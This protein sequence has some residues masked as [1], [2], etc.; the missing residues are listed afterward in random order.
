MK[1]Q[2]FLLHFAGGN[3]YSLQRI[4][5]YLKD[6]DVILPELPGRGK[7]MNECLLRDFDLAV[8]DLYEQITRKL[9]AADFLIYGHSM[10]AYLAIGVAN[11]L[12]QAGKTPACLTVS[13]NAGPG[14]RTRQDLYPLE[15]EDFI[16]E[17]RKLGGLSNE[18]LEDIE[19]FD[20]FEPILRADF[21]LIEKNISRNILPTKAP[22]FAMM[23]SREEN[24]NDI[25]NWGKFTTSYF[26]Y[27]ILEGNHFFIFKHPERIAY[28]IQRNYGKVASLKQ[29]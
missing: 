3:C 29:K 27:E 18:I 2:L 14:I 15:R 19:L 22:L 24:V 9:T 13:G 5:P 20:I 8:L 26:D 4:A 16:R 21:E 7:R 28:N 6:F 1:S 12:E 25:S 11:L 10:G 17:L 23:G